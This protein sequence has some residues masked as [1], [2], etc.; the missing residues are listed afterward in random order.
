LG[1]DGGFPETIGPAPNNRLGA[2]EPSIPRNRNCDLKGAMEALSYK[3]GILA[4][5]GQVK[6]SVVRG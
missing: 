5:C 1:N 2:T 6:T 3:K 4:P